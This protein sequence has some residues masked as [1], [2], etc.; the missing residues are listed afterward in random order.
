MSYEVKIDGVDFVVEVI[1]DEFGLDVEQ[2]FVQ[3]SDKDI[4]SL[5]ADGVLAEIE[6]ACLDQYTQALLESE[7]DKVR[8]L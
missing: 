5:L 2:V 7:L 3:G 8:G 6:N 4:S 1:F